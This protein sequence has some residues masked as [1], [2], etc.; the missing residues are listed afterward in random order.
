MWGSYPWCSSG[1]I[2]VSTL[3]GHSWQHSDNYM[4]SKSM[5]SSCTVNA[6]CTI[7]YAFDP[8]LYPSLYSNSIPS[9]SCINFVGIT[10]CP[11]HLQCIPK[12]FIKPT[13]EINPSG[14]SSYNYN[15]CLFFN[16]RDSWETNLWLNH[17]WLLGVQKRTHSQKGFNI[18]ESNKTSQGLTCLYQHDR[19]RMYAHYIL[20]KF[21]LLLH[22]ISCL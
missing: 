17:H 19:V 1:L 13:N 22:A 21:I 16:L 11:P 12:M 10:H 6:L 15:F 20:H 3:R 18:D 2:H 8:K 4:G 7:N 14:I 5:T 9:I